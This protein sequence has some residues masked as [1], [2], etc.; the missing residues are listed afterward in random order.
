[1][2]RLLFLSEVWEM[3]MM[4]RKSIW[5]YALSVCVADLYSDT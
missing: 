4:E 2:L 3:M 1:M 5:L